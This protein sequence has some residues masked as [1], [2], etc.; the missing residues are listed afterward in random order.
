MRKKHAN[1]H[2]NSVYKAKKKRKKQGVFITSLKV[3]IWYDHIK[4]FNIA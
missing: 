3:S 2:G 1:I 4:L